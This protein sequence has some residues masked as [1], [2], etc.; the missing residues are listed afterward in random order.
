MKLELEDDNYSISPKAED[1]P[2]SR[3]K[4][5]L[6]FKKLRE[7]A[8]NIEQKIELNKAGNLLRDKYHDVNYFMNH[9]KN[10]L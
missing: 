7:S 10:L 6:A 1:R 4:L 9:S 8:L 5:N 2:L 3:M